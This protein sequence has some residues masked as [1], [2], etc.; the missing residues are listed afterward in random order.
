MDLLA[1]PRQPAGEDGIARRELRLRQAL[2]L[3]G[4]RPQGVQ[5]RLLERGY[6]SGPEGDKPWGLR[7]DFDWHR[8]VRRCRAGTPFDREL[9]RLV[10]GE[11]FVAAVI[12]EQGGRLAERQFAGR[13]R[14]GRRC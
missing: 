1:A 7:D 13:P 14:C 2:H 10:R 6:A 11:G 5:E 8:L 9:R 12:G 3:R 4:W